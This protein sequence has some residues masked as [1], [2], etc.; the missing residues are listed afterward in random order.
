M[1]V[2]S[3]R[4]RSSQRPI[5]CRIFPHAGAFTRVVAVLIT[6]SLTAC[7]ADEPAEPV[8]PPPN[9]LLISIDTLRAD[10]LDAYGY[11]RETAPN[12]TRLAEQGALF[13]RCV[14]VSNWTLPTHTTLFTGL[15]P[16]VHG[17][18]ESKDALD[19]G[20]ATLGEAFAEAGYETAGW[21][22]NPFVDAKFGFMRGFERYEMALTRE[23][24]KAQ[25]ELKGTPKGAITN[26]HQPQPG[27]RQ[28]DYFVEQGA[29][30]TSDRALQFLEERDP[31]RPFLLFLHYNDVHS[32]YIP[33]A[34]YDRKFNPGYEGT[35]T[36][37]GYPHNKR[38]NRR[39][40]PADL[41]QIKALYDGEI[42][43]T[44]QAIGRVLDRLDELGLA[45]DTIVLVTSDHG[46]GFFEHNGKEHHYG[47]YDELVNI[48]FIV[49]YPV[50]VPAGQRI[51]HGV[52]QA[53]IAPTLLELARLDGLP[54]ADGLSWAG[55]L[56]GRSGGTRP[57]PMLS[58][59]IL[60][61]IL[62]EDG[63]VVLSLRTDELTVIKHVSPEGAE[64]V[65]VFDR[66]TDPGEQRPLPADLMQQVD[67]F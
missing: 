40:P 57:R 39:M 3:P 26:S 65:L 58:R 56:T 59:A 60:K 49:R 17:V 5:L 28:K 63:D 21:F 48:P 67:D 43:W 36:A 34:P 53:D 55:E 11:A 51:S 50:T 35:I 46:E 44:D 45:D 19:P 29:E 41:A 61:P 38:I 9:V 33:P 66:A 47:L 6:G 15:H 23:Q 12:L 54:E 22:N 42:A 31:A 10:H 14:A 64:K 18:E 62:D 13:E 25:M 30:A 52:S 37:E 32:D 16:I 7:G 8:G 1:P 2:P 4:S 27:P 24:M 20:R